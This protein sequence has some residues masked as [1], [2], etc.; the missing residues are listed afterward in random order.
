MASKVVSKAK[1]K[2]EAKV[3]EV[4]IGRVEEKVEA[5]VGLW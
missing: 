5:V 2:A 4:E 1:V 3:K